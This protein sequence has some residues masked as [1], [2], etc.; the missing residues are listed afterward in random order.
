MKTISKIVLGA[1]AIGIGSAILTRYIRNKRTYSFSGKVVLITGGS[2]GL[3]LVLARK[4]A[5]EGAKVAI[6]ARDKQEL[7]N[8]FINLSQINPDV[9]AIQCD[10]T[11]KSQIDKMIDEIK[12][13]WGSID[14]VINN[15]G[16]IQVGPFEN[17]TIEDFQ[18]AMNIH[19]WAPLYVTLAVWEDMKRKGDGRI[20]NIS[21]IGGKVTVPHLLPYTASKFA[22]T[23]LSDG[24]RVELKKYG[25][26]VTTVNPGLMRTGSHRNI[27]VKGQHEKEYAAF[28]VIGSMPLLT[29]SAEHAADSIIKAIV[30]RRSSI[31][32][33]LP[34]KFMTAIY[35]RFPSFSS[36]LDA[37]L[38][39]LLPEPTSSKEGKKGYEAQSS[40]SPSILTILNEKAA[41]VNN[42]M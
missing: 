39:N 42:E 23:G 35:E 10:V 9:F 21:S 20:V 7:E 4:F 1:A 5:A 34:A 22:L 24:L 30:Q 18:D 17:M 12:N 16:I 2:R 36:N 27:T 25:I 28:S 33:S 26:H 38:N 15:A 32:L 41:K 40:K 31:V 11:D 19:F 37:L 14:I 6:C 13:R 29:M 8:A 3:G